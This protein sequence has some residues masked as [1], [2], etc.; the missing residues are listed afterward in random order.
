VMKKHQRYLPVRD[1]DGALLPHFVTMANGECDHAAVRAGNE[2]VLRARYED[3]AFFY[4]HDL[5]LAPADM[6]QGL[7]KLTFEERLGAM[8]D[9]AA[10]IRAIAAEL[11][12]QVDLDEAER[13]VLL[14]AGELAKFDLGSHMVIE[15]SSLAGI[16]AREYARHA[17]E[18]DAVAEALFEME[19]PRSS[20]DRLPATA[21]GALLAIA[22]RLDLLTGL[23]AIG[24][25]PSGSSDPFGLRRAAL[26]LTAILRA[27]PRLSGITVGEGLAVAARHQ[28]VEVGAAAVGEARQFVARRFEQALLDAGHPVGVVRAVLPH[29]DTPGHAEQAVADLEKLLGDERFDRLTTGLQRVLRIVPA[30]TAAG[31]D[32][33]LFT[34]AAEHRLHETY[35]GVRAE[36]GPPPVGLPEFTAAALPLVD[37]IDAF[38]DE[39]LVMAEDP[40]V[41]ANR[42]G[43]LAAIRDLVTGVLDWREIS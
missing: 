22:D 15:L 8:A 6:R 3:A 7:A 11:A 16:M 37:P 27:Q 26:G 36:L 13:A 24:S 41:R 31:Y 19:L 34:D 40:A 43:L 38:F 35:S 14:R 33:A 21:P 42:L 30:E 23:F 28:P 18:G 9:R 2:A 1:R 32:P 29:A 10:R 5:R 39:V 4:E 12:L 17:G 25:A 20:G